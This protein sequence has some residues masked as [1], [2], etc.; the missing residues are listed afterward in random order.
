MTSPPYVTYS[1]CQTSCRVHLYRCSCPVACHSTLSHNVWLVR[2]YITGC[3]PW[4][5]PSRPT[6]TRLPWTWGCCGGDHSGWGGDR[7]G[8]RHT[9]TNP[10]SGRLVSF[11]VVCKIL[12][13]L[14]LL[15]LHNP[16]FFT[17]DAAKGLCL[18]KV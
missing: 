14:D 15:S 10:S 9:A 12:I 2:G 7:V 1:V 13:L 17:F 3:R 8:P 16:Y 4:R 18:S 6:D 11:C 5:C